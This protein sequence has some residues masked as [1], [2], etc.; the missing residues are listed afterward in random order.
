M[1]CKVCGGNMMPQQVQLAEVLEDNGASHYF[2]VT[3]VPAEVC[4]QCGER[5]ISPNVVSEL[6]VIADMVQRGVRSEK[7]VEVPV[8]SLQQ[9]KAPR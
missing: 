6:R 8:F 4:D 3:D 9:A 1:K 5:V 2:I 7:K